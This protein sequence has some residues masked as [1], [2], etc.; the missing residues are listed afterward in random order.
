MAM[1]DV[2]NPTIVDG[3]I[4]IGPNDGTHIVNRDADTNPNPTITAP[5]TA[6]HIS[7]FLLHIRRRATDTAGDQVLSAATPAD[8]ADDTSRGHTQG[9]GID[10]MA[11]NGPEPPHDH[12]GELPTN[13][14][15]TAP[16]ISDAS[17][18][19]TKRRK[20]TNPGHSLQ[21]KHRPATER[22]NRSPSKTITENDAGIG[23]GAMAEDETGMRHGAGGGSS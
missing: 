23:G 22:H 4:S 3:I 8:T 2:H 9:H 5:P 16:R 17:S 14:D 11:T 1:S 13:A 7:S 15:T 12:D 18:N 6:E 10:E 19:P 20:R 21:K